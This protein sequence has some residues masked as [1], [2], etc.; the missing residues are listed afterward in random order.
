MV[1]FFLAFGL[2]WYLSLFSQT[3][4]LHR[5]AAH[6]M[7]SMRPFW[8]RFF[9][10]FTW[11]TQG[12]SYL[13]PY[14]YGVMHRLHHAFADTEKDP[15]SPKYS[16]G[17]FSMMHKT[18]VI[19]SDINTGKFPVEEKYLKNL[20][21]WRSFDFLMGSWFMR[22]FWVILYAVFY[23]YF[24]VEWWMWLFFPITCLMGPVHGAIINYFAH[25][26]GYRNFSVTDTSRNLMPV[27][28][29]MM[30]EGFHNNHHKHGARPNFGWK[31][32][33]LDPTWPVIRLLNM[34]RI[35]RLKQEP[36]VS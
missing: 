19:Y 1:I 18:K 22:L 7:F 34:L 17:I 15:H 5:Y 16:Q 6:A 21:M 30:G 14:A 23:Y 12:S 11:I 35:I 25:K 27:D 28:L 3:F 2:Q 10:F 24:A 8:E 31:W 26:V 20:P 13:S 29:F 33:E 36:M 32:F 9:Y 4:F